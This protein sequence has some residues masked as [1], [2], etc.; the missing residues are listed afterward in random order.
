MKTIMNI[1][2][3]RTMKQFLIAL[4]VVSA[5]LTFQFPAQAKQFNVNS[6]RDAV[7][8]NPGDGVCATATGECTLRAAIQ[9]TNAL[10]GA[11]CIS[12]LARCIP[13]RFQ[14]PAR[15]ALHQAISTLRMT[16]RSKALEHRPRSWMAEAWIASFKSYR[17]RRS[18]AE[19]A[20]YRPT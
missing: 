7:D 16:L 9:E 10:R 5:G 6:T 14:V 13:S 17:P 18:V 2:G 11:D 4:C 8:A 15:I 1:G 3:N 12:S 20:L 19:Q